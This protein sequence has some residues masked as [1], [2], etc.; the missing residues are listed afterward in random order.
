MM[1]AAFPPW[2]SRLFIWTIQAERHVIVLIR[3]TLKKLISP[4]VKLKNVALIYFPFCK[5]SVDAHECLW[6]T[7]GL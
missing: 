2:P 6:R 7:Q 4:L 3:K 1:S 5:I